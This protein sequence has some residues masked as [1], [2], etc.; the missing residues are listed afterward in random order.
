M[1]Y[2]KF[3][4]IILQGPA[5]DEY[6]RLVTEIRGHCET[7]I[8]HQLKSELIEEEPVK[9]ETIVPNIERRNRAGS[10]ATRKISLTC[11]T[12]AR[13]Q[14]MPPPDPSL[15][16]LN[17]PKR[18]GGRLRSPAPS[19]IPSPVAS[20][21]PTRSRFQ[22]S[23]VS[24]SDSPVT[25]PSSSNVFFNSGSRF[26]VTMVDSGAP[27]TVL[28][29]S[30]NSEYRTVGFDVTTLSP[31]ISVSP[32][33][34]PTP[35]PAPLLS[36]IPSLFP[37]PMPSPMPS[38]LESP[39]LSP[40]YISPLCTIGEAHSLT[41]APSE[42]NGI[43]IKSEELLLKEANPV[44]IIISESDENKLSKEVK[45]GDLDEDKIDGTTKVL[46][47][48][49]SI[50]VNPPISPI[51][52]NNENTSNNEQSNLINNQTRFSPRNSASPPKVCK[53]RS[54]SEDSE[55][56]VYM[57]RKLPKA[58]DSLDL[59]AQRVMKQPSVNV[60]EKP[61]VSSQRVRKISSWV[62]PSVMFSSITQDDS[63]KPSSSLER[64]LGLF[65][66]PFSRSKVEEE[67]V[68]LECVPEVVENSNKKCD[69]IV[70]SSIT[71]TESSLKSTKTSS[72]NILQSSLSETENLKKSDS[73]TD[74]IS[75]MQKNCSIKESSPSESEDKGLDADITSDILGSC[76]TRNGCEPKCDKQDVNISLNF[77]NNSSLK[78]KDT[79]AV[80]C[81]TWPQGTSTAQLNLLHQNQS[82]STPRLTALLFL[83]GNVPSN[84]AGK[85]QMLE[86]YC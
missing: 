54:E 6:M 60:P 69:N 83:K 13:A 76:L 39:S 53:L 32:A 43:E 64:L 36:S 26:K 4:I 3:D 1:Y 28:T 71:N 84:L 23:R 14:A 46:S 40:T 41:P 52:S 51:T 85:N 7:N 35:I 18:S 74:I 29:S 67:P 15:Q 79:G 75:E 48:C 17:E 61:S 22:V 57:N 34:S 70:E 50:E 63:G 80:K 33:P 11:E 8:R 72:D 42:N 65:T 38:P 9:E 16:L 21:S 2:F 86:L 66:N 19:P 37:T 47:V 5:L 59:F 49:E 24:E 73:Q 78:N 58:T 56:D 10:F 12:F 55:K 81:E 31:N 82:Q 27:S 25:P 77:N 45:S 30:A 62:Q 44:S 20:P 68:Q